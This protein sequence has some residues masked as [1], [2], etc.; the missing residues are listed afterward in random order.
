[1]R[2]DK[3]DVYTEK[4]TLGYRGRKSFVSVAG[5][6]AKRKK[7][8]RSRKEKKSTD[9]LLEPPNKEERKAHEKAE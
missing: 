6:A 1:M 7:T 5:G 3:C 8:E 4:E 2:L 9:M